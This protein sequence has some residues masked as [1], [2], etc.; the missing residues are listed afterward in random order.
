MAVHPPSL[1]IMS[2]NTSPCALSSGAKIIIWQTHSIDLAQI[3]L[4]RKMRTQ[5]RLCTPCAN[6][7]QRSQATREAQHGHTNGFGE[8]RRQAIENHGCIVE[9]VGRQ[10]EH[11]TLWLESCAKT[12]REEDCGDAACGFLEHRE[13]ECR[14]R[15]GS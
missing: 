8:R 12:V 5:T 15:R 3:S 2:F 11:F 6:P 9:D 1:Q 14:G 13:E 4:S 7:T 10:T